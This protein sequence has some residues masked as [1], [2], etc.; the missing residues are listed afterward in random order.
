MNDAINLVYTYTT[1]DQYM[2]MYKKVIE[3]INFENL[4]NFMM[5]VLILKNY[6]K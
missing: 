6:Y 2:C 1:G 4:G 3:Y 5:Q